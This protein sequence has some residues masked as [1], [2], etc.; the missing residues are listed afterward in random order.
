MIHLPYPIGTIFYHADSFQGKVKAVREFEIV[1]YEILY[2]REYV[3][4]IELPERYSAT[5]PISK[6][7]LTWEDAINAAKGE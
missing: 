2:S 6:I 3:L 4:A 7:H 1:G 5:F